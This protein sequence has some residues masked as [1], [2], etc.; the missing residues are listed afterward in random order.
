MSIE[1]AVFEI[2]A[3]R[4]T[5][6]AGGTTL[7]DSGASGVVEF[8]SMGL[9]LGQIRIAATPSGDTDKLDVV[10]Y[11]SSDDGDDNTWETAAYSTTQITNAGAASGEHV[12]LVDVSTYARRL[13]ILLKSASTNDTW[14]TSPGGIVF[15]GIR[16][17]Y[18]DSVPQAHQCI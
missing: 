7:D 12:Q 9:L 5:I 8:G 2:A 10:V 16:K 4:Q 3:K 15:I 11:R 17:F 6:L 14:L 1:T 13:N 18:T